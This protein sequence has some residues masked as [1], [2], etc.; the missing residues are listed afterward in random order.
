MLLVITPLL[1]YA[2][3]FLR[4]Q[5]VANLGRRIMSPRKSNNRTLRTRRAR[6][7]VS[8]S[9][10]THDIQ[11]S[12][13][14]LTLHRTE[15]C[16]TW[17]WEAASASLVVIHSYPRPHVLVATTHGDRLIDPRVGDDKTYI[18]TMGMQQTSVH[19]RTTSCYETGWEDRTWCS[20][21]PSSGSTT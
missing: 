12:Y 20:P 13:P 19:G 16:F 3:F 6:G 11:M 21:S 14:L 18:T 1:R 9:L 4:G 17:V 5:W 8:L 10:G 15:Y 2:Q 7:E